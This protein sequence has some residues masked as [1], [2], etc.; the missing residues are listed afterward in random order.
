MLNFETKPQFDKEEES[1]LR[2]PAICVLMFTLQYPLLK[3]LLVKAG[4]L[5]ED[6]EVAF[7]VKSLSLFDIIDGF[8]PMFEG[9]N[10]F[11]LED[12]TCPPPSVVSY[13]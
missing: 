3:K 1:P 2:L 12:G 9:N 13:E 11:R 6:A 5:K 8:I 10:C 4:L 7:V